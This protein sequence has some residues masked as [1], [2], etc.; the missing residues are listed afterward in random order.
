M[1][2]RLCIS[3]MRINLFFLQL[4]LVAVYKDLSHLTNSSIYVIFGGL[5]ASATIIHQYLCFS[6]NPPKKYLVL[7]SFQLNWTINIEVSYFVMSSNNHNILSI[8]NNK[9]YFNVSLFSPGFRSLAHS[10]CVSKYKCILHGVSRQIGQPSILQRI[11]RL[12]SIIF[13]RH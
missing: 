1:G 8:I 10:E 9:L 2:E 5:C 7:F 4:I 6:N 12:L 11:K 3:K 13:G